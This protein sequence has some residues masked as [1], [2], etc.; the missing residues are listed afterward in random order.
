MLRSVVTV[1]VF[2]AVI[3][4]VEAQ[5]RKSPAA[6]LDFAMVSGSVGHVPSR[7]GGV[8]S[9]APFT[10]LSF[11]GEDGHRTLVVS[12]TNGDYAAVLQAGHYCVAAY[13][14]KT[15]NLVRLDSRQLE[16]IDVQVGK[17]VRLD[18]M[19]VNEG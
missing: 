13:N 16:C 8:M 17:D 12:S 1:L 9:D 2:G 3:L 7:S 6:H 11:T 4:F 15:G 14:I 18:V 10:I 19:L 5:T